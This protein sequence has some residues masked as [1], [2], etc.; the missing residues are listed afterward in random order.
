MDEQQR[1]IHPA[2]LFVDP[3]QKT[4]ARAVYKI[5][6]FHINNNTCHI[7]PV[8][9]FTGFFKLC[10]ITHEHLFIDR[11]EKENPFI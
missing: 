9:I 1:G 5:N 11:L 2:C 8:N 4:N 7:L 6:V 3:D 10:N